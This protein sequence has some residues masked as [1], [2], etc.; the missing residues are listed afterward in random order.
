MLRHPPASHHVNTRFGEPS[1]RAISS[2]SFCS[3]MRSGACVNARGSLY[4][5]ISAACNYNWLIVMLCVAR[6]HLNRRSPAPGVS[7]LTQ[8]Y[9]GAMKCAEMRP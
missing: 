2:Q 4:D 1:K 5:C 3:N 9:S 7:N 6:P 8:T